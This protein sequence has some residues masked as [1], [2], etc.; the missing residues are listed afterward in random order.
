MLHLIGC[1]FP[2]TGLQSYHPPSLRRPRA[3]DGTPSGPPCSGS[4]ST[5]WPLSSR[6]RS[7]TKNISGRLGFYDNMW[8]VHSSES[9]QDI[10]GILEQTYM[11]F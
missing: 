7:G 5:T 6:K 9:Q 3:R 2:C 11:F 4:G 10:P 8:K 1:S